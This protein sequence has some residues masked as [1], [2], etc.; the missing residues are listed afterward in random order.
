MNDPKTCVYKLFYDENYSYDT[1][2]KQYFIMHGLGLCIKVDINV[3]H[4][5]YA[6]TFSHNTSVSI[7]T[8]K[9]KYF[10]SLNTN[11]I[12]FSRGADNSNKNIT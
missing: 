1:K 4:V 12:V 6:R 9:K 3:A 10:L 11:A 2:I 7:D 8:K 5:F